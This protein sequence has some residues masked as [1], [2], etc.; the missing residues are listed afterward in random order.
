LG[1]APRLP[2]PHTI[3]ARARIALAATGIVA[4]LLVV[5]PV[6]AA[7]AESV[8]AFRAAM[9][10]VEARMPAAAALVVAKTIEVDNLRASVAAFPQ[11]LE[12]A[13]ADLE[14]AGLAVRDFS[15]GADLE[16][17]FRQYRAATEALQR[18]RDFLRRSEADFAAARASLLRGEGELEAAKLEAARLEDRRLTLRAENEPFFAPPTVERVNISVSADFGQ[19][20]TLF[21]AEWRAAGDADA[22]SVAAGR[23]ALL[24]EMIA[25]A[26]RT[27]AALK[28][29]Y[30]HAEHQFIAAD[31]RWQELNGQYV[32]AAN[33]QLMTATLIELS[34]FAAGA[35]MSGPPGPYVLF[36]LAWRARE[37]YSGGG[38]VREGNERLVQTPG[39]SEDFIAYRN[40]IANL[41]PASEAVPSPTGAARS[42]A[43]WWLQGQASEGLKGTVATTIDFYLQL[44][45]EERGQTFLRTQIQRR[46]KEAVLRELISTT[47]GPMNAALRGYAMEGGERFREI[48]QAV[49]VLAKGPPGRFSNAI[50]RFVNREVLGKIA[51]DFV[52]GAGFALFQA[53]MAEINQDHRLRIFEEM[54]HAEVDW[55]LR[56]NSL[57]AISAFLQLYTAGHAHLQ[58]ALGAA[59]DERGIGC[60]DRLLRRTD[61]AS[62]DDPVII[63]DWHRQRGFNLEVEF[64]KPIRQATARFGNA[65]PVALTGISTEAQPSTLYAS[66]PLDPGSGSLTFEVNGTDRSGLALDGEPGSVATLGAGYQWQSYQPGPDRSI[67]INVVVPRI[68]FR[69]EGTAGL[70][71]GEMFSVGVANAPPG[72][73]VI[74]IDPASPEALNRAG[75]V[76]RQSL[77]DQSA[78]DVALTAPAEPAAYAVRLIDRAS[79]GA[80]TLASAD[81]AVTPA[82]PGGQCTAAPGLTPTGA[83]AEELDWFSYGYSLVEDRV[84]HCPCYNGWS[85]IDIDGTDRY[86]VASQVCHAAVHAGVI[87]WSG[88]YLR[89]RL[90]PADDSFQL[91]GSVRN[92]IT[93]GA[94]GSNRPSF[95]PIPPE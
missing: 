29:E 61:A 95:S 94:Y 11:V 70:G 4:A 54:V 57:R 36:E 87:T 25:E 26:G 67:V 41:D 38:F 74:I 86:S 78:A 9:A 76:S 17:A 13:T 51:A 77:N 89:A 14:R 20:A 34:D 15:S 23:V 6:A 82:E 56:R 69:D 47:D 24:Q 48:E 46:G 28:A 43:R 90:F 88:G 40:A 2:P 39:L 66:L 18:A 31:T 62:V 45:A 19:I 8:D 5:T 50:G 68:A 53:G 81:F 49:A 7:P 55:F 58:R 52:A 27:V 80:F 1:D 63:G 93:S 79:L 75:G 32:S 60:C 10:Q 35:A 12:T 83:A 22:A 71:A 42:E 91:V 30:D 16:E 72:A 92:G 44:L 73:E 59:L 33:T 84:Y 64:S 65:A 37:F 3:A 21:E 85:V